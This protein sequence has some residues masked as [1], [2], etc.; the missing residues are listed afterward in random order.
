MVIAKKSGKAGAKASASQFS[1]ADRVT[2][3]TFAIGTV[4]RH[5]DEY[6]RTANQVHFWKAWRAIREANSHGCDI[7]LP[8]NMLDELDRFA[9][10][11]LVAGAKGTARAEADIARRFMFADVWASACR[12]TGADPKLEDKPVVPDTVFDAVARRHGLGGND[13]GGNLKM[14]WS[15]YLRQSKSR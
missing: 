9:A 12:A 2:M 11:S 4:N 15:R 13:P 6:R 8:S 7:A 3:R 10:A 14:Q 1:A 5:L